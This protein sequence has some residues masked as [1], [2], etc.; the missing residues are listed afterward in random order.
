MSH[1]PQLTE[2]D[3]LE[4]DWDWVDY[5]ATRLSTQERGDKR[6]SM[7]N[8]M[9]SAAAGFSGGEA[10]TEWNSLYNQLYT[11]AELS[12]ASR[13]EDEQIEQELKEERE[14]RQR[15]IDE[16]RAKREQEGQTQEDTPAPAKG[17]P[18]LLY[19]G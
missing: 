15:Q 18:K 7:L 8:N 6:F 9:L 4:K 3:I 16:A 12:E 2:S 13:L 17:T 14:R 19:H 10:M 1:Y 11:E 5:H